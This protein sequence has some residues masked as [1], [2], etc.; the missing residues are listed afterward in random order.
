MWN[1]IKG[2][3]RIGIPWDQ[4]FFTLVS[5]FTDAMV[6][7]PIYI[8]I[9]GSDS[10]LAALF[11]LLMFLPISGFMNWSLVQNSKE[12]MT[13]V[14]YWNKFFDKDVIFKLLAED[15][16]TPYTTEEGY[17][18]RSLKISESGRWLKIAGRYYPIPLISGV[19]SGDFELINGEYIKIRG[20]KNWDRLINKA[21]EELF[22]P[23]LSGIRNYD[24]DDIPS[25]R[26]DAFKNAWK[27]DYKELAQ[28]DWF[29]VRYRWEKEFSQLVA[30]KMSGKIRRS[31]LN[32]IKREHVVY[33]QMFRR[34]L[35]DAEISKIAEAIKDG[36]I[37]R[38]YALFDI[39]NYDDDYC[40]C[41][42]ISVLRTIGYPHNSQWSE[43]LFDCLKDI[44]KSYC[45]DAIAALKAYP[46][47][48]LIEHIDADIQ[49][50]HEAND[51]RWAAGLIALAKTI[52]YEI[53]L[54]SEAAEEELTEEKKPQEKGLTITG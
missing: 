39:T 50:A 36:E 48:E 21:L 11:L 14:P 40:V 19:R 18:C 30:E 5:L 20:I 10:R 29:E 27:G 51:L 17:V 7:W 23:V 35:T 41:N 24:Y 9:T 43:F 12:V 47:Q 2:L 37:E 6:I 38:P 31:N 8:L 13:P 34:V 22:P 16:F 28:A 53:T 25:N 4:T 46:K 32:E 33:K 26:A 54:E 45:D 52:E 44:E 42:G 49:K 3:L 15:K 1:Y